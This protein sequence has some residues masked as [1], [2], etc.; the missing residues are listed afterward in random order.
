[1]SSGVR[2][3]IN[4]NDAALKMTR[5]KSKLIS[6][7]RFVLANYFVVPALG[8]F[9]C[10]LEALGRIKFIHFERFPT[11]EEN[12]IILSN[13]PS[14]LEPWILPLM[15]FPWMNFPWVFSHPWS[16]IQ[17]SLS[18]FKE[19][20]KG[21]SLP[22]KLIPANVPDKNNFYDPLY[23]R[24]FRGINIP[25]D[26]NGGIQGRIGTVLVLK[27]I[28]E[29]GGRVLLFPEG[30]RTFKA[31]RQGEFKSV[32]GSQL[33]KLKEGAAWLALK[34]N[35]RILPIWVEGTDKVLP[36][37]ESPT[38][39]L[40]YLKL[41]HRI[42]IKVGS[43]FLVQ[44]KT[45]EEATSEITQALLELADESLKARGKSKKPE[46]FSQIQFKSSR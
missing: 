15:G 37:T 36:N 14:L 45:R 20:Q 19:W 21:F 41:W 42:T 26:R 22:K 11:W 10:L 23:L 3:N 17:C 40:R 16:R 25:V 29:N 7:I 28:L 38:L 34:T 35:A 43:P 12:L 33:G 2:S 24:L 32:N 18:W 5:V 44:G 1:M 27:K 13:H 6:E 30:T 4:S 9:V 8:V 39:K 31:V 46:K